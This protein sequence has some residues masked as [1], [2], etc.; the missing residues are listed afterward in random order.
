MTCEP[1]KIKIQLVTLRLTD[2][3]N[4]GLYTGERPV[5]PGLRGKRFYSKIDQRVNTSAQSRSLIAIPEV[6]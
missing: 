6:L 4:I 1:G 3:T 2:A 5:S